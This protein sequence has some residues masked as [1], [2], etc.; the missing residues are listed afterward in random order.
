MV[1]FVNDPRG[2]FVSQDDSSL[3]LKV[4]PDLKHWKVVKKEGSMDDEDGWTQS[5]L[6][7]DLGRALAVSYGENRIIDGGSLFKCIDNYRFRTL[8]RISKTQSQ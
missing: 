3:R 2:A 7:D 5:Y 4:L 1:Y 6:I 8:A